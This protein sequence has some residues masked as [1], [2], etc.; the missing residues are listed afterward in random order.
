MEPK[1]PVCQGEMKLIPAGIS[2]KSGKP[3]PEFWA[4]KTWQ[5][6][7]TVNIPKEG[8]NAPQGNSVPSRG[9]PQRDIKAN[10]NYKADQIRSF[11]QSKESSM[12]LF[13]ANRDAVQLTI[14]EMGQTVW[15]EEQIEEA[16]ERWVKYL[17][18]NVYMDSEKDYY[19]KYSQPF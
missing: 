11:Q 3:Y 10:M 4:C 6:K 8:E 16:I 5:C 2:K 7:G 1:C 15:Q 12:R 13:A 18:G 9:I 14:A 17:L 19:E